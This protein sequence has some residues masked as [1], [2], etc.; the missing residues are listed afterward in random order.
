MCGRFY[1]PQKAIDNVIM[2]LP[3]ELQEK[4]RE[5][6]KEWLRD[7]NKPRNNVA[8]T[9]QYPVITSTG[10]EPMRWGF[11]SDKSNAVFNARKES[12]SWGLWRES[13]VLRRGLVVVGGFYE[14]TGDKKARQPHAIQRADGEP[15]LMG[16]LWDSNYNP[17]T[18]DDERCFSIVTTPPSEW[19]TA[20]HD[21]QPLILDPKDAATWIDLTQ[22]PPTIKK[23]IDPYA[24]PLTEFE[25][26]DPKQDQPPRP[27]KKRDLFGA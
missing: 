25:C 27:G 26:P 20:L 19:M 14:W 7:L 24:G 3:P 4:A 18:E 23:L 6:I 13:L 8:P 15:M 22:K 12:L 2:E 17:K 16:V 10:V 11:I 9:Q 5:V 1:V 21:R